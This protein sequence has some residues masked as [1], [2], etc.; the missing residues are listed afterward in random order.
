MAAVHLGRLSGPVGFSRTVAIKRLHPTFAQ[1]PEFVAMFLDEARLVARVRHP[2]VVPVLDVVA[3]S[4]ELFLVMDYVEGDNLARLTKG[5]EPVPHDVV[6]GILINVLHG[7]HAAHEARAV[8]GERLDIVH[9]DVSPQ[10]ILVDIDGI[11]RV[12]DFGIAKATARLSNTQTGELKGKFR[13]M[14]LE[15][16][17]GRNVTHQT[18]IYSAGAVLWE[19]LTGRRLIDASGPFEARERIMEL[20]AAPPSR[21]RPEV[22]VALDNVVLR[23]L[24]KQPEA[25]FSTA[26]E[27]A[28]ALEDALQPAMPSAIGAWVRGQAHEALTSRSQVLH[29][30]ESTTEDASD[31]V[32]AERVTELASRASFASLS[33]SD[34][35]SLSVGDGEEMT[36]THASHI[37][38]KHVASKSGAEDSTIARTLAPHAESFDVVRQ[39]PA[40]TN[41]SPESLG[42]RAST[43]RL[44]ALAQP[45]ERKLAAARW[46]AA[47][48]GSLVGLAASVVVIAWLWNARQHEAP[49]QTEVGSSTSSSPARTGEQA[50]PDVVPTQVDDLDTL[51][52]SPPEITTP[53]PAASSAPEKTVRPPRRTIPRPKPATPPKKTAPKAEPGFG[54][55]TRN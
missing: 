51:S 3:E 26:S 53:P 29:E 43:V 23:A 42:Q 4:D 6:S 18:D 14:A 17:T 40:E 30:L 15:Q 46:G 25:R 45:K 9:R 22:P 49:R 12:T 27:M 11:A 47:A 55:F 52:S 33:D 16:I 34:L 54:S 10:N 32:L 48:L 1:N 44:S 37:S 35:K 19:L 41:P 39:P 5:Q 7:L 24:N 31:D 38:R 8:G 13:Y 36:A 2:N 28:T 20:D 21:Y 50:A